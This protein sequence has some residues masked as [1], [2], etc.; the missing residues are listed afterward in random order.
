MS[1]NLNFIFRQIL[2]TNI[3]Q[4]AEA[5]RAKKKLEITLVLFTYGYKYSAERLITIITTCIIIYFRPDNI[6]LHFSFTL[7]HIT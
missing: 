3:V 6:Y 1:Y 4:L 5:Y 2:R 7:Q